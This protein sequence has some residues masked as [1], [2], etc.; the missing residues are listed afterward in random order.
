MGTKSSTTRISLVRTEATHVSTT[1]TVF[2]TQYG[3]TRTGTP[4]PRW[5]QQVKEGSNASTTFAGSISELKYVGGSGG[6][7]YYWP[8]VDNP[9]KVVRF[10]Q[11][12]N[13]SAA[14]VGLVS[15]FIPS[16]TTAD[17]QA[18]I[19]TYKDIREAMYQISGPMF[20]AELRQTIGMLKSP[21]RSLVEY[22]QGYTNTLKKRKARSPR[23]SFDRVVADTWLEYSF[24]LSPFLSDIKAAAETL[25]RFNLDIRRAAIKGYGESSQ[26]WAAGTVTTGTSNAGVFYRKVTNYRTDAKVI[27]R[28]GLAAQMGY[29]SGSTARIIELSGFQFQNFIPT[30]WEVLPWSFLVDY[31]SNIGDV[32]EA[33]CTDT[34]SVL[35][36]QRNNVA[37]TRL[38][39]S[40]S[41]DAATIR[42]FYGRNL[43]SVT[44]NPLGYYVSS[45]RSVSRAP[46][47]LGYPSLQFEL[48][49]RPGQLGNIAA[50]IVS[51][52]RVQGY[53]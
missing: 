20:L 15:N 45:S 12:T 48:P 28:V 34:S 14:D 16:F 21:C 53:G 51:G 13:L 8:S 43:I 37:E 24:G 41:V 47:S 52:R 49:G 19:R 42:A 2:P 3:R 46:T 10:A 44:D 30:V 9:S 29:N 5:R 38:H 40:Y 32:I 4:N 50:L 7:K 36:V 25:A 6:Y 17:N 1:I 18:L 26:V 31:F 23:R 35:R 22:L 33:G 27:Y 11:S 39:N